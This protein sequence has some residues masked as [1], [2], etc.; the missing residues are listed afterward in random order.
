MITIKKSQY[1]TQVYLNGMDL[2]TS[3][4]CYTP[5][6]FPLAQAVKYGEENEV[7]IKVDLRLYDDGGNAEQLA[8]I[9]VILPATGQKNIPW[10][11]ELPKKPGGYIL[12]AAFNTAGGQKVLSR[13]FIKVGEVENY[14]YFGLRPEE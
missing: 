2:G 8:R 1:V 9:P 5:V 3:M 4:A 14:S 12:V 10:N 7:L 11:I 6:E 13:R